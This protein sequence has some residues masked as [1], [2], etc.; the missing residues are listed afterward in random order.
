MIAWVYKLISPKFFY[1]FAE[2]VLSGLTILFTL[3]FIVALIWGLEYAPADYQQG[4]G[5]RIIYLHVPAAFASLAIYSF[6]AFCALLSL[7][8]R[9]K[10]A[11]TLIFA[12]TSLGLWMTI[13][14][15]LTG[16]IWGKPMW[17]TWWI[18]DAR[19]TS[20]LILLFIYM[21]IMVLRQALI[22]HPQGSKVIAVMVL[23]GFV[24]IPIIHYSVNWWQTLHQG[25]SL[26]LLAK[27]TIDSSMLWPL[28]IMLGAFVSYSA[29]LIIMR[30]NTV[31]LQQEKHTDWVKSLRGH[32]CQ[33]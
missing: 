33:K 6:M 26:N 25:A 30:A 24:D 19:L 17:G 21:G 16:S 10:L 14:A 23:V 4:D 12:S 2:R 11:D 8:W 28:L 27:P 18:W 1:F 5:V 7:I 13:L 29:V 3:L 22:R 9:I 20:E 31:L 32:V 15:L